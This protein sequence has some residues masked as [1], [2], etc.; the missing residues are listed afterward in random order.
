MPVGKVCCKL[1]VLELIFDEVHEGIVV[2][3]QRLLRMV[4][5]DKLSDILAN[6]NPQFGCQHEGVYLKKHPQCGIFYIPQL[7][8]PQDG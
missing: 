8:C 1:D 5:P 7:G 3:H 2:N 6:S 4:D